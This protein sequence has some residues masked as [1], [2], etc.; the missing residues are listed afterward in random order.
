MVLVEDF[1]AKSN[2]TTLEHPPHNPDQPPD[3]FYLFP[4]IERTVLL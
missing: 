1:L 4:Q 2:M 3:N